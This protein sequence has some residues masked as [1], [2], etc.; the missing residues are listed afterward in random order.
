MERVRK[1]SM[2]LAAAVMVVALSGALGCGAE[3][4]EPDPEDV[5]ADI[6]ETPDAGDDADADTDGSSDADVEGD[7]DSGDE[8]DADG[9][10]EGDADGGSDVEEDA[11]EL[12]QGDGRSCETAFDVSQGIVLEE[13]TT[14]GGPEAQD[15]DDGTCPSGRLSGPEMIYR[16]SPAADTAYRVHVEPL[17]VS[18]DPMIYVRT[19]CSTQVCEA[20]TVF[21]GPGQSE[22]LS[23]EVPGGETRY[24]IVDG[25]LLSEGAYRLEVSI[26]E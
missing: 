5:G 3:G 4:P 13:Q 10:D 18:F 14:V 17:D 6:D 21:N 8:G 24:I 19:D 2:R 7:A 25:E 11:D 15:A 12:P 22:T 20:G 26:E 16:V 1:M 9:G 23:F